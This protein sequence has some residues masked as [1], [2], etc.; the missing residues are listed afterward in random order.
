MGNKLSD[1]VMY[2][3]FVLYTSVTI[4]LLTVVLK[5]ERRKCMDTLGQVIGQVIGHSGLKTEVKGNLVWGLIEHHR[6]IQS[7]PGWPEKHFHL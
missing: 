2:A 7:S 3:C 1:Q 6:A 4:V 5:N